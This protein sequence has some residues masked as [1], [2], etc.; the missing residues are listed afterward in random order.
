MMWSKIQD[1]PLAREVQL[2]LE[3]NRVN[4]C[5]YHN[6][7]HVDSM[8]RYLEESEQPYSEALDWAVLF[9]DSVYDDRPD[10]ESRSAAL[11]LELRD[12]HSGFGMNDLAAVDVCS[13]ILDTNEHL[14]STM[15]PLESSAIIRADLHALTSAASTIR[16]Y[17]LLLQ[18]ACNLYKTTDKQ[19]AKASQSF[20]FGLQERARLNSRTRDV[21]HA[22]FYRKVLDGISLTI[23]LS[24]EIINE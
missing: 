17:V 19:T 11:F 18:E 10:K 24:E 6:A 22:S 7:E 9:H 16:N 21:T 3:Q 1:T 8:Y 13:L 20:M 5:A 4:G 12:K 2:R 23:H 15:R 14:V